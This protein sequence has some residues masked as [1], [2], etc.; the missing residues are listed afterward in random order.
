MGEQE[1]GKTQVSKELLEKC[2]FCRDL[3]EEKARLNEEHAEMKDEN[4]AEYKEKR[5]K[6]REFQKVS[7]RLDEVKEEIVKDLLRELE[8]EK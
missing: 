2:V 7:C 5:E 8:I 6:Y 3:E 1:Q 4:F